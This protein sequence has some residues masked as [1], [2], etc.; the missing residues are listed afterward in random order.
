[1]IQKCMTRF[2]SMFAIVLTLSLVLMSQPTEAL[3]EDV[4]YKV[5]LTSAG[6]GKVIAGYDSGG[7]EL[8]W[9]EAGDVWYAFINGNTQVTLKQL[10]DPD[11]VEPA[12]GYV[13]DY[14]VADKDLY[15]NGG[16][17]FIAHATTAP[18]GEALRS[19]LS[20][21]YVYAYENLTLTAYFK[22]KPAAVTYTTDGYGSVGKGDESVEIDKEYA[23]VAGMLPVGKPSGTTATPT[24]STKYAFDYWTADKDVYKYE[25]DVLTTVSAGTK[26]DSP[27][28]YY[29]SGDVTYTAH[30]KQIAVTI[31]YTSA[32]NGS[33]GKDSALAELCETG[34]LPDSGD[35]I[36]LAQSSHIASIPN[37]N[38][39]FKY[40]K[41]NKDVYQRSET[42]ELTAHPAG[43]EL[44]ATT[45]LVSEDIT[46]TAYFKHKP[47]TVS[48]TTDGHGSV[49]KAS[50]ST[51]INEEYKS[52]EETLPV[53][54]PAGTT[55]TPT[56]S[57]KYA[58]DYWTADKDVYKYENGEL[59]TVAA[60]TKLDSS[61]EDYYVS[62]DVTFTAH[63]KY[64]KGDI[65]YISAGNGSVSPN[66]EV[67]TFFEQ[68]IDAADTKAM[69]GMPTGATTNPDEDYK[70]GY[71]TASSDVIVTSDLSVI[72]AGDKISNEQ[73][74]SILVTGDTTFTAHFN[75]KP[76]TV[77]YT[78]DGNGTVSKTSQSVE[79]TS[80][81]PLGSDPTKELTV[82]QPRYG[83][84]ATPNRN[85][86]LNYWTAS[87]DVYVLDGSTMQLSVYKAGTHLPN[88]NVELY[89][90][91]QDTTYTAHF[92]R[93]AYDITYK[94]AGHGAV[95][96]TSERVAVDSTPVG[97]TITPDANYEFSHWTANV[98]VEL[99]DE[100][101]TQT[102]MLTADDVESQTGTTTIAAGDS[103]TDEQLK[104]AVSFSGDPVF[105]AHFK[106]KPVTVT[107][108]AEANGSVDKDSESVEIDKEY[109]SGE[110]MLPVG[111]LGGTTA[112]P[113]DSTKYALD[114][115]TA[116]K[117]IYTCENEQLTTIAAG[118]KLASLEGY[119][120]ADAVTFTAHFKHQPVTVAYT[121]DGNGSVGMDSES[122][123]IDKEYASGEEML[124]VGKPAGT[125]ATPTDSTKYAFDYWTAD[126]DI[127]TCENEQLT[128]I[129]AGTKLDSS[130]EDYYVSGDVTYTAHFKR[131]AYAITYETAGHG[132]LSPAS[133]T[134][135]VGDALVGCKISPEKG[136]EF[137][138]WTADK[139]VQ[140]SVEDGADPIIIAIG[141]KITAEQFKQVLVTDDITF[142][143]H[144][145]EVSVSPS[146]TDDPDDSDNSND[147][148]D[149]T[150]GDNGKLTPKTG[151]TLP[152]TT[153]AVAVV[154]LVLA[155]GAALFR[156]RRC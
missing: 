82:G 17:G 112:T 62:G 59:T 42:G 43:E 123:E 121:S 24:D 2:K 110:E 90:V 89:Y 78:T 68:I 38:Y 61:P 117:D 113:A 39:E 145:K 40:W 133:E 141:E 64:L 92:F 155:A 57:T 134:L 149:S 1:M 4:T 135:A 119:Y 18:K 153:A 76:V 77:S 115:W 34:T 28:D 51:E 142:T 16:W 49:G 14:W 128:T 32:G 56:D 127:Y 74:G 81:H 19:S 15:Y 27:S 120:V 21:Y 132:T 85:Y 139:D 22:R 71:W 65:T 124:P 108:M 46:F 156:R 10:K 109:A 150:S 86:M 114:Y 69:A 94:T 143:A 58:F 140:I 37:E 136:Y 73:L 151:D 11:K 50:E 63:F 35:S 104:R 129:A 66:S 3:A 152:G 84:S 60:G 144:F 12:S 44:I 88:E 13:L 52:G 111:K 41:A 102:T 36:E 95:S 70:F 7:N 99:A 91:A 107:Y 83:V 87:A 122:V 146:S 75:A 154:A 147:N 96:P 23:S 25:N 45:W 80:I 98:D 93:T 105:T 72:A 116:D 30:F 137:S 6:N 118:T 55:A 79:R 138:H 53:G 126:K 97:C 31:N 48:Y 9:Y 29:V 103:I 148:T 101:A 130:P 33:V 5:T 106:H 26:I 54:K 131:I 100:S 125:T 47:V 20:S 8:D 67:V